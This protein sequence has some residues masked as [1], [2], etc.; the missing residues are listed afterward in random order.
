[1]ILSYPHGDI[2]MQM[3]DY[4]KTLQSENKTNVEEKNNMLGDL[5]SNDFPGVPVLSGHLLNGILGRC[6]NK[7]VEIHINQPNNTT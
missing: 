7:L 6:F 2:A 4:G 5:C 3:Y 1:M